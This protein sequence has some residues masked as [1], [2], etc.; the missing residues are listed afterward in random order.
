MY[1]FMNGIS[2]FLMYTL[3]F[4]LLHA[5]FLYMFWC[6]SW[7][8]G[9]CQSDTQLALMY[10]GDYSR[11]TLSTF[12]FMLILEPHNSCIMVQICMLSTHRLVH[13]HFQWY[14]AIKL[15][16]YYMRPKPSFTRYHGYPLSAVEFRCLLSHNRV[17]LL[18]LSLTFKYVA[19]NQVELKLC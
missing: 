16:G 18:M 3:H 15:L 1:I 11:K 5:S 8:A 7:T 9:R 12:T 4:S 19:V 6:L 17:A 13:I 2:T 10:T 14:V